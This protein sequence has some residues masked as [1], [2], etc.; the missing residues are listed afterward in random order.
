MIDDEVVENEVIDLRLG[1]VRNYKEVVPMVKEYM[2]I[3]KCKKKGILNFV[4]KQSL[5]KKITWNPLK[6]VARKLQTNL[7]NPDVLEICKNY[8]S[9]WIRSIW[10]MLQKLL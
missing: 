7:S 9:V 4:Y 6:K 8:F 1:N 5:F 2:T 10:K 3:I